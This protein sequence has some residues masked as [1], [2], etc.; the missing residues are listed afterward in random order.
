MKK[1]SAIVG[2]L[3]VGFLLWYLIIKPYD[4]L[5]TF[6]IKTT[7]GTIN[8]SIKLWNTSIE[9]SRPIQQENLKNLTQQ[10]I[11]KDSTYNYEWSISSLNDS[12]SKVSVYVKDIDHSFANKI[13]IPF[14]TTDFEK[15]TQNTITDFIEKLKE[16]LSKTRVSEVVVDSTRSTYCAYI[17][18][19]GLQIEK[20][21]GMMQNYSLLTSV[22]SAENIEMNGTPFVEITNWNTQNDSITYNFCFPV[23]K[24][25]SLPKDSRIEYKQYNGVKALKAIYNGNY[26]TSDRA[27]YALLDYAENHDIVVAKKPL[28]VFYSNPNFG[29]DEL[30]WKAE[31]FI[32]IKE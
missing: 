23:I 8:Q 13:S 6:K 17:P 16:H 10:I 20:A 2:F 24:S 15:R 25:D 12:I 11:I 9:N 18:M 5:V 32:P 14:G 4:Y 29:G 26:I 27:W 3:S 21:S 28:E 30:Q 1:I 22:L 7:A 19:K 31:I